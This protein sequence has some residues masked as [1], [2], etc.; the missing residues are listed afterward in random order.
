[1]QYWLSFR[2]ILTFGLTGLLA[3]APLSLRPQI[4]L[5]QG[6]PLTAKGD[7][8]LD[9]SLGE[10]DGGSWRQFRI[11]GQYEFAD[12]LQTWFSLFGLSNAYSNTYFTQGQTITMA[13][14]EYLVAYRF[15]LAPQETTFED[16][17]SAWGTGQ[18]CEDMSAMESML[19]SAESRVN[20]SLLNPST[21]GSLNDIQLVDTAGLI[22]QS[23]AA[24]EGMQ[25]ACQE[26]EAESKVLEATQFLGSINRGQQAFHMEMGQFSNSLEELQ[27]GISQNTDDYAYYVNVAN[28]KL[29]TSQA[30]AKSPEGYHLV[31]AVYVLDNN[32]PTYPITLSILCKKTERGGQ[33]PEAPSFDPGFQ[34][35][36]CPAGTE[37][38]Y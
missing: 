23:Q 30:V 38:T 1:M 12:W 20:L 27:L 2:K 28:A 9:L 8:P 10:L 37:L 7:L 4:A 29:A 25:E 19:L 21:I 11:S 26:Q 16:M 14:K 15:P 35:L 17:F 6:N 18:N 36:T 24:Y 33:I 13:G 32:D 3:I 31:G 22:E 34:D 5:A